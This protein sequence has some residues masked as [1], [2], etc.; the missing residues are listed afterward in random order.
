MNVGFVG[1]GIMGV[2]MALN[3]C[4]GGHRLAVWARRPEAM[5]ALVEAGARACNSPADVAVD[6]DAVITIVS[7]TADVEQILFGPAGVASGIAAGSLVIDMSTISPLA[8][9]QF[10][11]R[12]ADQGVDM[13]DA[14]VSGGDV[15]AQAGTLS[16]MVGGKPEAFE[17]AKALFECM[18]RNIV[19]IGESGAGQVAKMC[20]QVLVASTIAAVGESLLLA[21]RSGVDPAKVRQALLGGFANSRIL[22]IHG[23]R[24][25]DRQFAPGFKAKLHQKDMRSA[26]ETAHQLGVALPY[27]GLAAQYLNALVGRGDGELDTSATVT[28]LEEMVGT[29]IG[30]VAQS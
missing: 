17:R 9:R 2:P 21:T 30:E 12:L 6:C 19:Y 1:L 27:A 8:T 3:L 10:A 4:K 22:E 20:N 18:G 29:R 26:M 23:Q 7:D 15:G 5:Q 11:A 28:L 14:P 25:L 13:L 24:M 16:I